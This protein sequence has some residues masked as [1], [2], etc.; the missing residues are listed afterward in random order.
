V[1]L[2]RYDIQTKE[3]CQT[4][5]PIEK[6]KIMITANNE[7]P[8]QVYQGVG[9]PEENLGFILQRGQDEIVL[10]K[11]TNQFTVQ[12]AQPFGGQPNNL[13]ITITDHQSIPVGK[14]EAITVPSDQLDEAMNLARE[15]DK[16]NF[17]S[18]VYQPVNDPSMIIYLT[19][20]VTIQFEQTVSETTRQRITEAVGL[21][22]C[23]PLADI[24]NTFIYLISNDATENPLKITNKLT[25]NAE[26]LVA[27]PN[28]IVAIQNFYTPQDPLFHKQWYLAHQGGDQL[29]NNSHIF[30]EK[31]WDIT[32][33][34]R[35][36]IVAITD[37]AIDLNHPDLQ[38][39]G[40]IVAPLDLKD[41][42]FAPDPKEPGENH[43]T[44]CA[45]VAI[46]E[47]NGQGIVGVA[48]GCALMPIRTT[49]YL[50]DESIEK[51]FNWAIEKQASVIS[52]SW[53]ASAI[54]FPLSLRQRAVISKAATQ[55]RKGKGCV[56]VFA[57][58]NANRPIN[59]TVNETGWPN[60]VVRG[61][62][63]WLS[64][65]TVHPD[66]IT[67]AASTSLN[68]KSFYS[69]WGNGISVCAPSN[70]APPGL[71]MPETGYTNTPPKITN[72][73]PG[74]GIFTTDRIGTP[75]YEPGD[76]TGSFGGT[77]SATPVV[78]G[79]AALI[80]SV[81]PDLKAQD[82]RRILQD[83]ADKIVD[84]NPDPQLGNTLGN[85][86]QNGYS[87]WFGYGK[88]N[89]E[90]AVIMAQRMRVSM[91]GVTRQVK[92]ENKNSLSIPDHNP[93]GVTSVIKISD[94]GQLKDIQVSVNIEHGY[95]GDIDVKLIAPNG[96]MAL[97]QG[98]TLGRSTILNRV[99]SSQN[100]FS[101]RQ[102]LDISITG[103]WRLIVTDHADLD[104][105][106]LKS[107]QLVIGI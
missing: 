94:S 105:G 30:A 64:G 14:L 31:A 12:L 72:T 10:Q 86:D 33:G 101:L 61:P 73:I 24:P 48:P 51:I 52:C 67:V 17:A 1:S 76:F 56:I 22:L 5:N 23:K 84:P 45:G 37:D 70:N 11:L 60:D 6:I 74:L 54:Y 103:D 7:L 43:G 97:L 26:I 79:V 9:V 40:K 65:F 95:L 19:N 34:N 59:G 98:R 75:G 21:E 27:E 49:G 83:T 32:K 16:V 99:Y 47:E 35:A 58:G 4:E 93:Q 104:M 102:F 46:A 53:G 57:A 81:N 15:S 36:I 85:Y 28:I 41:K 71:W 2:T 63:R 68:Q 38:G 96:E 44:A 80:L 82:V 92:G 87:Q 20:Q 8:R 90:K 39:L 69:N 100:T 42:D 107:W 18:H 77:S 3:F 29:A 50:D 55:G 89:A 13:P 66:V 88:V 91:Q 78:A 106:V 62:T 25:W